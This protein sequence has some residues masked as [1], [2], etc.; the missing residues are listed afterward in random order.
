M[1][2]LKKVA[3]WYAFPMFQ[4]DLR[5]CFAKSVAWLVSYTLASV[6]DNAGTRR[7]RKWKCAVNAGESSLS[8][9]AKMNCICLNRLEQH[10]F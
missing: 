2:K 7:E 1:G 6:H 10:P 5:Y 3:V 4:A 8:E 9:A